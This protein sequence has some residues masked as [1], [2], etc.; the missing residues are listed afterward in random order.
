MDEFFVALGQIYDDPD[1]IAL[2]KYKLRLLCQGKQSAEIY[3]SEFQRWAADT[4]WNNAALRSQFCHGLSERLKDAFAFHERPVSLE[5]AMSLA[6]RIDR[7]LIERE[8]YSF[9]SYSAQGHWSCLMQC[10]GVSLC[11][12]TLRGGPHAAGFSCL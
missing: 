12:Y 6:V 11:L 1:R 10:A 5:S 4:G 3:C 8:D 9:L 2:A 7:R